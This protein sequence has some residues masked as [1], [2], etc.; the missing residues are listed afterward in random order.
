MKYSQSRK[1]LTVLRYLYFAFGLCGILIAASGFQHA[2]RKSVQSDWIVFSPKNGG[3]SVKL[4]SKPTERSL[5]QNTEPGQ[6]SSP[7]LYQ[8]ASEGLT[9]VITYRD[10]PFYKDAQTSEFLETV[11]EAGI[12]RAGG[13]V[14]SNEPISLDGYPGREV[15][16]E[17]AGF[18]YQSRVYLIKQRLYVLIVWLPAAQTGSENAAKFFKSF[19]VEK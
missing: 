5:S 13:K 1:R 2:K 3:F 14:T 18:F 19:Q 17:M 7:P 8:L 16:G 11:A 10:D 4:P 6:T 9:Y 12:T 15:K